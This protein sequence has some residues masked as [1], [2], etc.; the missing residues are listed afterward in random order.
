LAAGRVS[1]ALAMEA[2]ARLVKRAAGLRQRNK[3]RKA[4]ITFFS[5]ETGRICD[6]DE[7]DK[8]LGG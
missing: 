6:A 8:V 1:A 2:K 4:F 5:T 3:Q 7:S